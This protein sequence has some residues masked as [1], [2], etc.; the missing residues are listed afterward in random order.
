MGLPM[1]FIIWVFQSM[2]T[3]IAEAPS[4]M[5]CED[6]DMLRALGKTIREYKDPDA[7]DP[8]IHVMV[9]EPSAHCVLQAVTAE[10]AEKLRGRKIASSDR[11]EVFE[12]SG[13]ESVIPR[14]RGTEDHDTCIVELNRGGSNA[15][16]TDVPTEIIN[17][18]KRLSGI[19]G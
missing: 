5:D 13:D 6:K 17:L 7:N 2:H 11:T 8:V 3:A 19:G 12:S 16:G 1:K 15:D 4:H 18:L 9:M 10:Q 14:P